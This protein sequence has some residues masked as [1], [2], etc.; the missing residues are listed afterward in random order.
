MSGCSIS[1][2]TS[3]RP[4]S[5]IG[6]KIGSWASGNPVRGVDLPSRKGSQLQCALLDLCLQ[7]P[8][9][10]AWPKRMWSSSEPLRRWKRSQST[11]GARRRMPRCRRQLGAARKRSRAPSSRK[12]RGRRTHLPARRGESRSSSRAGAAAGTRKETSGTLGVPPPRK[13][14]GT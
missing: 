1:M 3:M 2:C 9:A 4:R 11:S 5:R 12:T 8:G 7:T 13:A 6:L 10:G 14:K